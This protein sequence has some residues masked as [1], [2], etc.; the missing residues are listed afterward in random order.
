MIVQILESGYRFVLGSIGGGKFAYVSIVVILSLQPVEIFGISDLSV[1][2]TRVLLKKK[3]KKLLFWEVFKLFSKLGRQLLPE[4]ELSQMVVVLEI[5]ETRWRIFFSC[6]RYSRLPHR[7][8]ED[9]D[10]E[11]EDRLVGRGADVS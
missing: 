7:F 6:R 5:R 9:E 3:K 10:A 8:G 2:L 4:V 11:P 1:L